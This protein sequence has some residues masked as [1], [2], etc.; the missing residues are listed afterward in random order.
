MKK[1]SL[2]I[3]ATLFIFIGLQAQTSDVPEAPIIAFEETDHP[4]ENIDIKEVGKYIFINVYSDTEKEKGFYTFERSYDKENFRIL[5][6]KAFTENDME[7]E[8]MY[9]FKD[10]L[11]EKNANYRIYRFTPDKVS[12]IAEYEY[13]SRKGHYAAKD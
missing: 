13:E 5:N 8:I 2:I 3:A 4:S 7:A 6:S 11:P 12:L 1:L 9:S 10:E